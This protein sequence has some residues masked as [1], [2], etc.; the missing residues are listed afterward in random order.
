MINFVNV[1]DA[2]L[3]SREAATDLTQGA[4]GYESG[5]DSDGN[6]QVT[7]VS[8]DTHAAY[9]LTELGLVMNFPVDI[10][11][12]E[13]EHDAIAS[14][15]RVLFVSASGTEVEDD[16]LTTNST[17]TVWASAS[18]G[19]NLVINNDGYLTKVGAA[20]APAGATVV[21]KFQKY[22]NGI[23]WYRML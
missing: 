4:W 10:Q 14:G 18:F 11:G 22:A 6:A 17:T 7:I 9:A 15:D 16:M 13:A 12:D 2:D 23:V 19:D 20:D 3:L 5:Y 1:K 21:A 8:T